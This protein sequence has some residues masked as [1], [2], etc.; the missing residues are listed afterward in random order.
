MTEQELKDLIAKSNARFDAMSPAKQ[1]EHRAAQRES[2]SRA[3]VG[4]GSDKDEV[5]YRAALGSGDPAALAEC[6]REE[7]E[8][9]KWL[10]RALHGWG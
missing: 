8:R 1:A 5:K 6:Q 2:Y 7:T 4:F 10:D 9:L 3:N